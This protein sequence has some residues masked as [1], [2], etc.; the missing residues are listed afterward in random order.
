MAP[1]GDLSITWLGHSTFKLTTPGGKS[2]LIDPWV[3]GNPACP[4]EAKALDTLDLMLITHAHFD[5][6]GD[7][8]PIAKTHGPTVVA[9]FEICQ[10]LEGKG[11]ANCIGMNKGGTVEVNGLKATMVEA[12]HSAGLLDDDGRLIY[13]G[14]PAGFVLELETGLRLYHAGDTGVFSDMAIIRELYEPAVALLPIGSVFTMGPREAAYACTLLQPKVVIPMHYGTFP[15]LTG[16]PAELQTLV[17]GMD[18]DVV[19]LPPGGTHAV[20]GGTL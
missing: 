11:V 13:G 5:H 17:E 1:T 6:M 8:V 12:Q 10:W 16:T 18:L 7:A 15:L 4:E 2:V 20:A 3:G 14:E 9:I 19:V